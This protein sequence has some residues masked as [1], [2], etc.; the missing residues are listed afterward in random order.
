MKGLIRQTV[1]EPKNSDEARLEDKRLTG[2]EAV[3]EWLRRLEEVLDRLEG[4]A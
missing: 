1:T 3:A 2:E 4:K